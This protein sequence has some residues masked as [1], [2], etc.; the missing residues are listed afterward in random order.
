MRTPPLG[1]SLRFSRPLSGSIPAI[2][3]HS[4]RSF[5]LLAGIEP[6]FLPSQGSVLSI[7]RQEQNIK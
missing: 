5:V 6:A 4:L 7:E 1:S 3:T 2:I